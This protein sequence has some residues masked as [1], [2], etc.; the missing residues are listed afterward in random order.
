VS[1]RKID[2]PSRGPDPAGVADA[3]RP[4]DEGRLG[5]PRDDDRPPPSVF[6]MTKAARA[7]LQLFYGGV[8]PSR[9]SLAGNR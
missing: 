7:A 9:K 8:R 5:P 1:A 6:P 3:L 4:L 2:G